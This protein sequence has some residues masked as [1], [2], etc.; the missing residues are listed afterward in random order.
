MAL[1]ASGNLSERQIS[2]PKKEGNRGEIRS[3]KL[4]CVPAH[5]YAAVL[6]RRETVLENAP[7]DFESPAAQQPYLMAGLRRL[8]VGRVH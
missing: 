7:A 2:G 6:G 4:F 3:S 8:W 1:R 5:G